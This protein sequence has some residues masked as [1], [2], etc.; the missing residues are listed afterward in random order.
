M[1]KNNASPRNVTL[2]LLL[3]KCLPVCN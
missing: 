2:T 3:P 1:N